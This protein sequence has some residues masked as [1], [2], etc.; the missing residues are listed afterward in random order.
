M[1][2]I[3]D[4]LAGNVSGQDFIAAARA[5]PEIPAWFQDLIPPG[6]EVLDGINW[7]T[8]N[9]GRILFISQFLVQCDAQKLKKSGFEVEAYED[10]LEL[11]RT[12]YLDEDDYVIVSA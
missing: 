8:I 12:Y 7:Y 5:N 6:A 2:M 4:Y 11:G 1:K 10:A 3:Q 9:Y